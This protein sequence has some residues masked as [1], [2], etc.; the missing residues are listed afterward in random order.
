MRLV[1]K[2]GLDGAARVLRG[3]AEEIEAWG[4]EHERQLASLLDPDEYRHTGRP[5]D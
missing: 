2:H 3:L 5:C 1:A 4:L